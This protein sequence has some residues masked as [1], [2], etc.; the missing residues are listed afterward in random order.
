MNLSD[1]ALEPYGVSFLQSFEAIRR[2]LQM[3]PSN[4]PKVAEQ[5][6]R[7]SANLAALHRDLEQATFKVIDGD[8]YIN[9]LPLRRLS[10]AH[11]R[12]LATWQALGR[13]LVRFAPEASRDE[14]LRFF[15]V[16]ARSPEDIQAAGGLAA[17]LAETAVDH[18]RV[19]GVAAELN[20]DL[21]SIF[22]QSSLAGADASRSDV[23]RGRYHESKAVLAALVTS[24]S[25]E[26]SASPSRILR[27][28]A[29][30]LDRR[31][32]G[33]EPV[34]ALLDRLHEHHAPSWS[35]ALDAAAIAVLA[36]RA[37]GLGEERLAVLGEAVAL[38]DMGKIAVSADVLEAVHSGSA[39]AD[40][41][42]EY[43]RHPA[44][45][46]KLL[47]RT[48]E[49][50][51]SAAIV[52]LE[53]HAGFD[54]RGFPALG[55]HGLHPFSRL[56]AVAAA[57][58]REAGE[59]AGARR[60]TPAEAMQRL[61]RGA[62]SAFEPAAVRA[63]VSLVGLVPPGSGVK[64]RYGRIGIAVA[65]GERHRA[66]PEVAVLADAAG[67]EIEPSIVKTDAESAVVSTFAPSRTDA[68]RLKPLLR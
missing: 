1:R 31:L 35:H 39:A 12:A 37:P 29:A 68:D 34:A 36:G 26:G 56:A 10:I 11:A 45:G 54:R 15:E 18:I 17:I 63:L 6:E 24:A 59:R 66:H 38:R 40:A 5:L 50:D 9:G 42:A 3:Y 13:G 47:S 32:A 16:L 44:E 4:H 57:Y 22:D 49:I 8:F 30:H 33:R 65:P 67:S 55:A 21:M 58:D 64:L 62:G 48:P 19:T 43:E 60:V 7:F 27:T 25:R 51:A 14:V 61:L 23:A 52:A 53:H 41:R 28:T 20:A 2:A 46:A